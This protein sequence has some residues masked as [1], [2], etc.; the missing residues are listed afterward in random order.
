MNGYCDMVA[1]KI[2]AFLVNDKSRL[3]YNDYDMM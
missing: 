1:G 2:P 3:Q